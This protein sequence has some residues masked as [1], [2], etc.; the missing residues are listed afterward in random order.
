MGRE[1]ALAGLQ[2]FVTT[3]KDGPDFPV[4]QDLIAVMRR[5]AADPVVFDA[6][7]DQWFYQVAVPEFRFTEVEKV[8]L[9]D[10][11]AW[12]V[13]ATIRNDGTGTVPLEVAAARGDRMN[14]DG[15]EN[16]DY[17]DARTSL[18]IGPGQEIPVTI[19]CDFEPDRVLPDPDARV[20]QLE[21]ARALRRL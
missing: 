4:L 17:R 2:E 3:F 11:D 7:V 13:R 14:K 18:T 9:G 20:L 19:R 15:T 1:R 21:R 12:E 16:P 8:D 5:H 6:F 10:G